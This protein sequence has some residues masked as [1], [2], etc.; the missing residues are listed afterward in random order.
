M[1]DDKI[2]GVASVKSKMIREGTMRYASDTARGIIGA[3]EGGFDDKILRR[4]L[5]FR[6][7]LINS[8]FTSITHIF[9]N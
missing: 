5:K 9:K 2:R 6:H 3:A 8:L 1:K 4:K 7:E